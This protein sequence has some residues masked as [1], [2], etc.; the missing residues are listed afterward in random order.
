[1]NSLR[2]RAILKALLSLREAL[3]VRF[4]AEG[5]ETSEIKDFVIEMGFDAAQGYAIG[6]PEIE[7]RIKL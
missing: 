6:R 7:T 2:D 1:L 3:D 4:I 5:V